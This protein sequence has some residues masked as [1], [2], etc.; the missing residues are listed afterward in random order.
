MKL[1]PITMKFAVSSILIASMARIADAATNLRSAGDRYVG[2]QGHSS[3]SKPG[4]ARRNLNF[5]IN[6]VGGDESDPADFPY[7]GTYV[8][9]VGVWLEVNKNSWSQ[10]KRCS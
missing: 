6:I 2:R 10:N 5:G 7:F 3:S 9:V 4:P 8:S 1:Q